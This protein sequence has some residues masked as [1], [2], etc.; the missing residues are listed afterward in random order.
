MVKLGFSALLPIQSWKGI[1]NIHPS[2]LCPVQ[3][4]YSKALL[5]KQDALKSRIS[6]QKQYTQSAGCI[7]RML[8]GSENAS[9]AQTHWVPLCEDAGL[10][11]GELPSLPR[12]R[13]SAARRMPGLHVPKVEE[14][15][16]LPPSGRAIK[17][18]VIFGSVPGR[19]NQKWILEICLL[20]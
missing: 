2:F 15:E 17:T 19:G 7:S 9:W 10:A 16:P 14:K 20:S 1:I 6:P 8:H 4:S 11:L 18:S 5:Q 13:A 3:L 12:S